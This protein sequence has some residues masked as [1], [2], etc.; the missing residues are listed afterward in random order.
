MGGR[1]RA[2]GLSGPGPEGAAALAAAPPAVGSGLRVPTATARPGRGASSLRVRA[3]V[4]ALFPRALV[5]LLGLGSF[6][7]ATTLAVSPR[8]IRPVE[9]D[10]DLVVV[11]VPEP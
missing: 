4:S 5:S 1:R 11:K 10:P 8:L 6:L 3:A 9:P 2:P 7:L